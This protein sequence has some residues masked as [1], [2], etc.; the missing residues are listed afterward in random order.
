MPTCTHIGPTLLFL[1]LFS[2]FPSDTWSRSFPDVPFRVYFCPRAATG[3]S[4]FERRSTHSASLPSPPPRLSLR[5]ATLAS[6][7]AVSRSFFFLFPCEFPW[8]EGGVEASGIKGQWG[9]SG[10]RRPGIRCRLDCACWVRQ[11][12]I[13]SKHPFHTGMGPV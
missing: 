6:C 9:Q 10:Q 1:F 7:G 13:S 5:R 3:A 2:D 4:T 12:S 11:A 8:R